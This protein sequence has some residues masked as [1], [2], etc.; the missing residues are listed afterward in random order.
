[1][2]FDLI[3][4]NRSF[5][6]RRMKT[7]KLEEKYLQIKSSDAYTIKLCYM[8]GL[9]IFVLLVGFF[10]I[11]KSLGLHEIISLHYFNGVFLLLGLFFALSSISKKNESNKIEYFNGIKTGMRMTLIAIIPFAIFIGLYLKIDTS[12]MT[13]LYHNSVFGHY[14]TPF[15]AGVVIAV[16]GIV[17]GF[18]LTFILMPYFKES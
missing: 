16:E 15:V 1:M 4:N 3:K 2:A 17:S 10:L 9:T 12:F 7:Q 13:F 11:M 14:L 18:L 8:V 5:K 6:I